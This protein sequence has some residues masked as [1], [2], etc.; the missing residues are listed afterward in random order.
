MRPFPGQTVRGRESFREVFRL[1]KTLKSLTIFFMRNFP[2]PS[3]LKEVRSDG[4]HEERSDGQ[5]GSPTGKGDH[6][7]S[8]ELM[9]RVAKGDRRA[10]E[11]LYS[12]YKGPIMSY[13]VRFLPE[14]ERAEEVCQEVFLRAYRT[15][16]TY[17]ATARVSTWLW[18]IAHNA[19]IDELRRKK[20]TLVARDTDEEDGAA[21]DPIAQLESELPSAEEALIERAREQGLERCLGRLPDGQRNALLLRTHSELAYEEIAETLRLSLAAVKT[22]IHRAKQGLIECLRRSEERS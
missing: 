16:E 19:A 13:L 9:L 15:R 6:D 12:R 8:R 18:T 14:R 2:P 17:A 10:F 20:E 3:S 1:R 4:I 11:M 5:D 7:V 22:A 21:L